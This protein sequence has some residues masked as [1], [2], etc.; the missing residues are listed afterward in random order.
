MNNEYQ[1]A[2]TC[3]TLSRRSHTFECGGDFCGCGGKMN[4]NQMYAHLRSVHG[5]HERRPID[6]AM[7]DGQSSFDDTA[8][9]LAEQV[10]PD[11]P[12]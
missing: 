8:A 12:F 6:L 1:T 9:R 7:R 4:W 5:V 3:T 10:E 11:I 2:I